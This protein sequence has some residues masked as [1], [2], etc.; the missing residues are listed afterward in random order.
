MAANNNVSLKNQDE[1]MKDEKYESELIDP[2]PVS[3]LLIA[4]AAAGSIASW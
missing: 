2:E 3:I 4:L 1:S